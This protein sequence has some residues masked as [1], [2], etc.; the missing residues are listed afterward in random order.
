MRYFAAFAALLL[1][2]ALAFPS[3]SF[4][5]YQNGSLPLDSSTYYM[6]SQPTALYM[7][8]SRL[9]VADSGNGMLYIMNASANLTRIRTVSSSPADSLLTNPMHMEY[10]DS[11]GILYIA[12]G[13]TGNIL[14]YNGQGSSVDKWN[15]S[16]TN[17]QKAAGVALTNDTIYVTDATRGQVLAFSR[18]TK[19]YSRIAV[20]NGGSDGLLS[21]PQDILLHDGRFYVSDAAKGMIFVYDS[22]FTFLNIT[23]GRGKGGVTLGS[24]RGM[25]FDDNRIYVADATHASVVAFSLD[26]YP[27]DVLNSSTLWGNLSYPE[28]VVVDNGVLYVADT[29]NRLIKAFQIV[30]GAGDPTV[31]AMI[32]DA[33]AACASLA[34]AQAVAA[35]LNLSYVPL[36]YGDGLASAQDY[37]D[38][39]QFSYA[40]T[41]AQK[42]KT[43]CSSSQS[44]L[45]QGIELK[46]R[47]LVQSSQAQ[48][49]PY[50]NA[51]AA[52]VPQL[53]QFDNKVSAVSFALT[54][55]SYS[56][57]ADIALTLP[58]LASSIATGAQ[59]KETA[60]AEKA[61]NQ[62][63]AAANADIT[64]VLSQISSLQ[65][66]SDLYHQGINLS[67]SQ[68][69]LALAQQ[70]AQNGDFGAVNRSL[71][72]ARAEIEA[73]SASL[74]SSAKEID[75]ALAG[76]AVSEIEFNA[77]VSRTLLFAPDLGK[78]KALM[79]QAKESVYSS[80]A[81]SL[82]MA[83]QAKASAEAKS[84]DSQAISLAAASVAVVL[85]LI[86]LIAVAVI[87]HLRGRKKHKGL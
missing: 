12:G 13:T 40:S 20:Q 22:N 72:L 24:P 65:A 58:S 45:T 36:S 3:F 87:I 29:N 75:A 38:S 46:I 9:Y 39:Y 25:D 17:L 62:S 77:T 52:S 78:E 8:G 44:S 73:Y 26:G 18:T 81:L 32:S 68:G 42:A 86:A 37:Y 49:A 31:L 43:D 33:N 2:C 4:L 79:L 27:V 76:L 48:V 41:I 5:Y 66:K 10:E 21:S 34:S 82:Q 6:L 83:S 14:Y 54:A 71:E 60:D 28:D 64:A 70:S 16:T 61:Q 35:K 23:F 15:P 67:V 1:A 50:R 53:V 85:F 19:A 84:R 56:S 57:A 59:D 51:S 74:D 30:K 55:K 47:Q 69:Q 63:L 7:V 80:P 11:T